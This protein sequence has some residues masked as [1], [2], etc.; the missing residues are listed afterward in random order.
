M[1]RL[2]ILVTTCLLTFASLSVMA[3]SPSIVWTG[4]DERVSIT[5]GVQYWI[6]DADASLS[7]VMALS[8]GAWTETEP[9]TIN[10]GY[11]R[12]VYWFRFHI[13]H[14]AEGASAPLLEI[15][16]P[17]L[18]DV[19]AYFVRNGEVQQEFLLGNHRPFKER[20]IEHRNFVL[21]MELQEPGLH[22]VYLRV[23]T[24][25]SVQVPL[26]LWQEEA[27]HAAEQHQM[28]FQ[29]LY[30]GIVFVMAI[31]H[32][33]IFVSVRE[34]TFLYYS[35]YIMAMPL[36]VACLGGLAFQF[37][38]PNGTW[39]N[40]QAMM[41][42]LSLTVLF[43]MLYSRQFLSI[44]PHN[45][46]KLYLLSQL[47]VYGG[48]IMAMAA[49]VLPFGQIILPTI[50]LA[51]VVC[52]SGLGMGIFRIFKGDQ[53]ARFYTAAWTVMLS[54]GVMLAMSKVSV[55]P[56]NVLTEN[57]AQAG[58]ALAVVL[59]ALAM[60][61]RLNREK[62]TAFRAQKRLLLEERK[63][64]R[65]QEEAL[66]IQQE[67]N[68]TLEHRVKERTEELER[69]NEKLRAMSAI[70][71]L[72]R[73]K[74]RR[75]FEETFERLVYDCYEYN[76]PLSVLVL[77]I[78]HFKAF[79]DNYG[80]MVGDDCLKLVAHKVQEIVTRPDDLAARYGGEE[81]VVLLPDTPLEGAMRVG[82]RIRRAIE[83]TPFSVGKER[84]PLTI[85]IGVT[86]RVPA[87]PNETA[88]M[89]Q[90]ADNAL[91]EAKHRGRNRVLSYQNMTVTT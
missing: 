69:V 54:G 50:V 76:R 81:F 2:I 74:N 45:H 20:P 67:A 59:L 22:R 88:E 30:F 33:C 26:H 43:G 73:L 68:T 53:A 63:S 86:S 12:S 8:D 10:F 16:Y 48:I 44:F 46:P 15:E 55:I 78:D 5:E 1:K 36:F 29:G 75:Y 85:S 27:F 38:W 37:L 79:N 42:F 51:V 28:I 56:R 89:F 65:A 82:E 87:H 66:A 77:D 35:V 6:Q 91:Y 11:D 3:T 49:L 39:W 71:A 31:Y 41:L 72:T 7:E 34:R 90:E 4:S 83:I 80:H 18:D 61:D 23:E 52:M 32:L 58:S 64:R 62:Q 57:A 70:D 19:E 47:C 84:T 21:P 13:D 25:T 40:D 60:A 14:Q 24:A 17:V 9:G